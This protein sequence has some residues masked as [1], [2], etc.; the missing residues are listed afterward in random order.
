MDLKGG[1]KSDLLTGPPLGPLNNPDATLQF[2]VRTLPLAEFVQQLV[3]AE[4][5]LAEYEQRNERPGKRGRSCGHGTLRGVQSWFLLSHSMY[6][7]RASHGRSM[8][9]FTLSR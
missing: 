6:Q 4:P 8:C 9:L 7:T 3:Q 5:Q 2:R 1:F